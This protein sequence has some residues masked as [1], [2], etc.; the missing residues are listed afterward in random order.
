MR[1]RQPISLGYDKPRQTRRGLNY[2]MIY[3]DRITGERRGPL[4]FFE[5]WLPGSKFHSPQR[6]QIGAFG[7]RFDPIEKSPLSTRA[8]KLQERLLSSR[9]V[10]YAEDQ[11]FFECESVLLSEDGFVFPDMD[12]SLGHLLKSDG[13]RLKNTGLWG[14]T[15]SHPPQAN[16]QGEAVCD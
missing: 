4:H 2:T 6:M 15:A 13:F 5:K 1:P 14:T 11:M 7:K 9:I 16:P 8:W 12:F 3:S 10:R